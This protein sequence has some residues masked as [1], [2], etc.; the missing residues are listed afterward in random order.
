MKQATLNFVTLLFVVLTPNVLAQTKKLAG[1][2][3]IRLRV[4]EAIETYE[5]KRLMAKEKLLK[6]IDR[7]LEVT[8]PRSKQFVDAAAKVAVTKDIEAERQEFV[9]RDTV[10]GH[11]LLSRA[12]K[13]YEVAVERARSECVRA[14]TNAADRLARQ[15]REGIRLAAALLAE[16]RALIG[17]LDDQLTHWTKGSPFAGTRTTAK[18]RAVMDGEVV[19]SSNTKLELRS[20]DTWGKNGR[21]D[22]VWTWR[23]ISHDASTGISKFELEEI[24]P[25]RSPDRRWNFSGVATL[26]GR[27]FKGSYRY[28]YDRGSPKNTGEQ[29]ISI[30]LESP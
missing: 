22:A 7:V 6:H 24:R 28:D 18:A 21:L 9:D 26:D 19:S 3:T 4:D 30:E 13:T 10:P 25:R 2:D 15:G 20:K 11:P 5:A 1:I 27:T 23:R 17:L 16:Q 8:I 14:F 12:V 29:T